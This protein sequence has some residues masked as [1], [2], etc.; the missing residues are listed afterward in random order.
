VW[1]HLY[2]EEVLRG[3]VDLLEGLLA[4]IWHGLHDQNV[5]APTAL[6]NPEDK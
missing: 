6:Q 2:L 3:A 4:R 1:A 5:F